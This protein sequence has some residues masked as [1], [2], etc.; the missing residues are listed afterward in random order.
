M[1]KRLGAVL[2]GS[3]L[4]S[5][6]YLNGGEIGRGHFEWQVTGDRTAQGSGDAVYSRAALLG[7]NFGTH[8]T[9]LAGGTGAM[10]IPAGLFLHAPNGF[11]PGLHRIDQAYRPDSIQASLILPGTLLFGSDSGTVEVVAGG[12]RLE[13]TFRVFLT[14]SSTPASGRREQLL[15][16][17]SFKIK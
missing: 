13:G 8:V 7:G 2:I 14:S 11:A 1:L 4:V 17:G 16:T 12:S 5:C 6:S 10:G 15:V 9:M 3:L